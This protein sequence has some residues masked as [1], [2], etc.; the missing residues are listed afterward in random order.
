M[1]FEIIARSR[2]E[3]T[4]VL[5]ARD[6]QD[7]SQTLATVGEAI[8]FMGSNFASNR[9]AEDKWQ[10]AVKALQI[11]AAINTPTMREIAT[12]AVMLLLES[13]GMLDR[14]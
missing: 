5:V 4:T 14:S 7:K 2:V 1:T 3:L 13:E 9:K 6:L 12:Q 11:A 8:S 10:T